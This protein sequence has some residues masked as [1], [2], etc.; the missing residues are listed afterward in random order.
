MAN[1]SR[2]VNMQQ[3]AQQAT[4][5]K[6]PNSE[7]Q[8]ANL[9]QLKYPKLLSW[10]ATNRSHKWQWEEEDHTPEVSLLLVGFSQSVIFFQQ[11]LSISHT[12]I[13]KILEKW[14]VVL[15]VKL[16]N[17]SYVLAHP[18]KKKKNPSFQYHNIEG[19]NKYIIIFKLFLKKKTLWYQKEST[20]VILDTAMLCTWLERSEQPTSLSKK[21]CCPGGKTTLWVSH[22]IIG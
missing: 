5:E 10:Q 14:N 15:I 22:L 19:D 9:A 13:G 8:N 3:P 17:F 2:K 18:K 20:V 4:H 11:I 21:I 6:C 1:A 16:T 12:K 7:E